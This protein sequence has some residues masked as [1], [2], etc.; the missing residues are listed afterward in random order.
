MPRPGGEADK[1][2]NHFE[3]LWTVSAVLDVFEGASEAITVE[4]LGDSSLGVEFYVEGTD[5]SRHF[6]SVKR[7][8]IGGDWSIVDLCR[9]DGQTGRSVLG[10]L[11]QK[12]TS[13]ENVKT[14]FVSSTGANELRELSERASTASNVTQFLRAL[15]PS[16]Q[17]KAPDLQEKF[18][19]RIVPVC[20]NDESRAFTFLEN[21]EVIL[22][23]HQHLVRTVERR[24]TSVLY[25]LDGS[26]LDP[27]DVRRE[28]SEY[29][30]ERLGMR[31]CREQVRDRLRRRGIGTRDWKIDRTLADAVQRINDRYLAT[32]AT[33]LINETHI[34]RAIVDEIINDLHDR[35]RKGVLLVAPG[36]LGKSC[37]IAQCIS[38]LSAL[39]TPLI[40]LRMDAM[41]RCT[42]SLQLGQQLDLP[43]SPAV[44]L[45]G[46]ADNATSVLVVDQLDAMSVVS[47][48]NPDLWMAF[49][50]LR[51]DVRAYPH[52]KMILT[53]R[54]F[55]LEHDH[56]LR[57]LSGE[58]S[59]YS[60]HTLDKLSKDEIMDSLTVAGVRAFKPSE[61]QFE[62][63]GVPFHLLLFLQGQPGTGFGSAGQLYDAYW[64]RKRRN[65]RGFL[66]RAPHWNEVVDAL[67]ERM[68]M[69]QVL[70]APKTVVDDW[71]EDS[72]AM[73]SEHVLV[74]TDQGHYRFFHESFFDYAYARRFASADRRLLEFLRSTEQHLFR[75]SQVRQILDYRREHDF[76]R[77]VLDVREIL[78]SEAVRFHIKRMVA[79][80][81][82]RVERPCLQDWRLLEPYLLR[83]PLSRYVSRSL[84][85]HSGWFDLLNT[86][87][88]FRRWLASED[89]VY[90]DLAIWYLEPPDL[91]EQRSAEIAALI[92]PY[93]QAGRSWEARIK[94]IMSWRKIHSSR[95]MRS[96]H[97]GM[98]ES[99]ACDDHSGTSPNGGFWDQYYGADKE[100]PRFIIDV[101]RTWFERSVQR[102]DDGV[103]WSTLQKAVQNRSDVGAKLIQASAESDPSY[104]VDQMLSVVVASIVKTRH[105]DGDEVRNRMW[106]LLSNV[107]N[108]S[109]IDDA[110][111]LSLRQALQYLSKHDATSLRDHVTPLL[112]YPDQTIA[113]L[114]LSAWQENPQEFADE[115]IRCILR[116]HRRLDIG[117]GYWVG[118]IAGTGHCAISRRAI[119]AV[120]PCCSD[121]LFA[122]LEATIVGYYTPYEARNRCSRGFTE[123]L[124]L[125]ALDRQR[126][127]ATAIARVHVLEMKFPNLEDAIV[128]E[129]ATFEMKLV[130]SPIAKERAQ[131][132]TDDQWLS[133]MKEHRESLGN[134]LDGGSLELSRLLTEFARTDRD[135][136][137]ALAIRMSD[138][139]HSDY[140]SAILDGLSGRSMNPGPERDADRRKLR[141][142]ATDVFLSVVDRAHA[143][144]GKPCGMA[145]V[146]SIEMLADRDLPTRILDIVSYYAINDPDPEE[147]LWKEDAGENSHYHMGDPY[148]H[149]NNCVRGRAA[150]AIAALLYSNQTRLID[151]RGALDALSR[152][153][154]VSVRTCAVEALL[155]LLNF[156]RDFAVNLVVSACGD[157][158]ETWS[159]HPFERFVSYAAHTHYGRLR[160]LL[161]AAL[162][163]GIEK[164]AGCVAR[165]IVLAELSDVDVGTDGDRVRTGNA[166]MRKAVVRVY[167]RNVANEAV[168]M[169]CMKRLEPFLDDADHIVRS[170]ATTA[171][172]NVSDEWL[173][174]SKDFVL[175]FIE[176]KAFDSE[177]YY[178]LRALEESSLAMPD[179]I[180][181]AAERVLEFLGE[182][183]THVAHHESMIAKSIATLVV[184]QYQQAV[185]TSM[186]TRCLDLIDQMEEAGYFGVD[187]ELAKLER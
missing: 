101:L 109:S 57:P 13:D 86:S 59:G 63:L 23:S 122:D 61:N 71:I 119:A 75:R 187:T 82:S 9:P 30:V 137:A 62:I 131:V 14:C 83:G 172:F 54:D 104:Y 111:L 41:E 134:S 103:T 81:F 46:L 106:P 177:P 115:C 89:S 118:E 167:A 180:C 90:V 28:I 161:Q 80:G 24:I 84:H 149:G 165:Q 96:L 168:G 79:S 2:G 50:E 35:N 147:E 166:A 151:L 45:A 36:G 93:A 65:L 31:L 33:E 39:G 184:R 162:C 145:I 174:R 85:G 22:Q 178:V 154:I 94:R 19:N 27:A 15:S 1:L 95:E 159:T 17:A 6:H 10:D 152:D 7:Q 8:K 20:G 176:S 18:R 91:Q 150:K 43:A 53:C 108:P 173:L 68:S 70:F 126:M 107:G 100:C 160:P 74:N 185:D 164:A 34:V 117:H 181:R 139:I 25:C 153:Q 138:D 72:Q 21:L 182:E 146:D 87:G 123:L 169:A 60:T 69:D 66:G 42:T 40:S 29:V 47:G 179:V 4:P 49:S 3:A 183:G 135:R 55:D 48:R 44:V 125:R 171:F 52:M 11:F 37:V 98:I 58:E 133:A 12:S 99:G 186:S 129:D 141:D 128:E 121:G 26:P 105:V 97:I 64:E 136:F 127:S 102:Y 142:T 73:V 88:V 112:R 51:D 78:E 77:Y 67:T 157:H 140:F 130:G 120:S 144:P 5:G 38:R 156:S 92:S 76:D 110:I 124:L 148:H 158:Q 163:S 56:R 16:P 132:L 116:D 32:I 114:M 170:E 155:P 143:L 175:R 113:Y